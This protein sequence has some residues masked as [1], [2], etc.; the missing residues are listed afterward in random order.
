MRPTMTSPAENRNFDIFTTPGMPRSFS[1]MWSASGD[2]MSTS[3]YGITMRC[4]LRAS[5]LSWNSRSKP[6]VTA[7]T[8]TRDATPSTTP[9]VDTVVKAENTR[10]RNTT[11]RSSAASSSHTTPTVS[12][13]RQRPRDMKKTTSP[14]ARP[15]SACPNKRRPPR[16][17]RARCR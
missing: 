15:T 11:T 3:P 9:M 1:S 6:L 16:V 12:P 2:S 10:M 5:T 13:V 17:A 7:R 4:A 14:R 8:T